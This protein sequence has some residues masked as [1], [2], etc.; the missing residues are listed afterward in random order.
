MQWVAPQSISEGESYHPALRRWVP[1]SV[2]AVCHVYVLCFVHK[3]PYHDLETIILAS[4][5][6]SCLCPSMFTSCFFVL[7]CAGGE[8]LPQSVSEGHTNIFQLFVFH[9]GCYVSS[10]LVLSCTVRVGV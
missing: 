4:T 1:R 5:S 6:F 10:C 9:S 8:N 2:F 7:H 3:A